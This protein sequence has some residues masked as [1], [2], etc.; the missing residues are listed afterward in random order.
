[1]WSQSSPLTRSLGGSWRTV[2]GKVQAFRGK[3]RAIA[4]KGGDLLAIEGGRHDEDLQVGADFALNPERPGQG[5]V[6]VEMAFVE[7]IED[8]RADARKVG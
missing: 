2:T 5:D 1:M 4:E 6:T 7:L 3:T 8:D